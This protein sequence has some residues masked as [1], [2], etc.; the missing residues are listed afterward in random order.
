MSKQSVA[1]KFAQLVMVPVLIAAVGVGVAQ[2]R[3][4]GHDN[5]GNHGNQNQQ[6]DFHFRDQDRGHFQSHYRSDVSRWQQRPQARP[7][8][9]RGQRIP[10]NYRLRAVPRSYYA[11][12][13]PPPPGYQYGYYEGYVVAY[14]PTTRIIAD[15]LDLVGAVA[16]R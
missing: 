5:H 11:N 4:S 9:E 13:P 2:G 15:V 1:G 10:G 3:N 7:H 6:N 16:S 14:N 8:F 12:V